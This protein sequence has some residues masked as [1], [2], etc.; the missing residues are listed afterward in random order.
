M[1]RLHPVAQIN[2]D[3]QK[4]LYLLSYCSQKL[5]TSLVRYLKFISPSS[6]PTL[7]HF[8]DTVDS[9]LDSIFSLFIG[10]RVHTWLLIGASIMDSRIRGFTQT[11]LIIPVGRCT[12]DPLP[13]QIGSGAQNFR[14]QNSYLLP[15]SLPD[16]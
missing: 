9:G 14:F 7:F 12:G 15:A 2:T 6:G 13:A 5:A 1:K 16:L 11:L 3:L 8:E 10:S 4:C